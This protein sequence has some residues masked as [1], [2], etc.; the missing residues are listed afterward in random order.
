MATLPV[1]AV[2]RVAGSMAELFEPRIVGPLSKGRCELRVGVAKFP[3]VSAIRDVRGTL[4]VGP[5]AGAA[6]RLQ[7]ERGPPE[8][9]GACCPKSTAN[10]AEGACAWS[11]NAKPAASKALLGSPVMPR[12]RRP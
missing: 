11:T 12:P 1:R 9:A 10:V 2:R 4:D 8:A 7:A 6:S 3:L 5:R